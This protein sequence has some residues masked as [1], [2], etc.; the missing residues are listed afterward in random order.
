MLGTS[1]DSWAQYCYFSVILSCR[2][3]KQV[4]TT[5]VKITKKAS[6]PVK[7]TLRKQMIAPM[8]LHA[9]R[10]IAYILI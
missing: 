10:Y 6:L 7:S 9:S 8:K 4:E 3:A 2:G 1:E 5:R